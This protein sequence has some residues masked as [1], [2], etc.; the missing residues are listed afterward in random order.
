MKINARI[1]FYF[2]LSTFPPPI[3]CIPTLIL[4]IPILIPLIPTLLPPIPLIPTLI[5]RIPLIS[6]SRFHIPAFTDTLIQK[7]CWNIIILQHDNMFLE[8][9]WVY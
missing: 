9:F 3:L 1:S 6:V 8:R 7:I 5:P 4:L 2:Y